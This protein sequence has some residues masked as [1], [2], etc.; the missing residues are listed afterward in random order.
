MIEEPEGY[1]DAFAEAGATHITIHVETCTNPTDVIRRIKALGCKAGIT[2]NP[3][4]PVSS[5]EPFLSL[6]DL[7]LVMTVNPG[8]GGQEFMPEV[9]PKIAGLRESLDKIHSPAR[10]EVDGGISAK[11]MP[12][13]RKAGAD[14]FVAGNF[15][16]K[17]PQG[18]AEGIRSLRESAAL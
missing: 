16:F 3:A 7:V 9:L 10:L 13:V 15:V 18:I 14:T 12:Q 1:I 4:T 6:A 11:T 5:I 8:Y 2:L 17:H